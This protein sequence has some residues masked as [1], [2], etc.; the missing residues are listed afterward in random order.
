MDASDARVP[1]EGAWFT[2]DL[3]AGWELSKGNRVFE[4]RPAPG[5]TVRGEPGS[6]RAHWGGVGWPT[7]SRLY[8]R[9]EIYEIILHGL[10]NNLPLKTQ[11]E[12]GLSIINR[13]FANP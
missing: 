9:Q 11:L 4:T 8:P 6:K 5:T 12:S 3:K 1:R 10:E 7:R 2:R 13:L